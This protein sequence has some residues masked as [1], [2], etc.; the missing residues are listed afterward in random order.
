MLLIPNVRGDTGAGALPGTINYIEGQVSLNGQAVTRN[1]V[2]HAGLDANQ[3]LDTAN[4]GKAEVLLSPGVYL[5][6]GANSEIRMISPELVDPKAEVVRGEAMVEVDRKDARADIFE[7]GADA[8]IR[9][10]GLYRFD[11][12]EGLVQVLDGKIEVAQNGQNKEFGKGKEIALSDASLKPVSFDRK[13]AEASDALYQW[14]SVRSNE[15]AQ[16]NVLIAENVYGGYAPFWGPGWYWN[17]YFSFWSWMPGDGF[18][19]SP[20]GFPFYS[21][22]YVVYA[23]YHYRAPIAGRTVARGFGGRPAFAPHSSATFAR[24]MNVRPMGGFAGHGFAGGVRGG[25]GRR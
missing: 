8:S 1:Q 14:S 5:R 23:P 25:I 22:A 7:R 12:D 9:K 3:V 11:G 20:F 17:P 6:V 4:G 21:P 10:T 15:L 2:G 19:Y 13:S 16:A 18:F 24:P